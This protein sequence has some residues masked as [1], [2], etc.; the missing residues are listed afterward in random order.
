MIRWRIPLQQVWF[1]DTATNVP[2]FYPRSLQYTVDKRG[3]TNQFFYDSFG[4]VTQKVIIGNLTGEGISNQTATNTATYT[5]NN[6]PSVVKD[7]SGNGV[8]FTYDSADPFRPIQ[9]VRVSGVTPVATNYYA[10]TNVAQ[11]SSL[12]TTNFAFGLCWQ[13][14]EGG[15]TNVFGFN[16]NGFLIQSTSYPATPD[17]PADTDPAIIHYLSYNLRG[18]MY[19]DQTA[20]GGT[21]QF[22]FD[23]MGRVISKQVFDQ[24]NNN[25]SSE[26]NYYN[27]NGELEWYYGTR[28]NPQDYVYN[29]YDGAGRNIQQIK[30]RSQAKSD[31]TGVEAPA[32]AAAYATTFQTFDGFGDQTSVTDPRGVVITNL[33]DPLGR[34]IQRQ[35]WETNG[36]VLKTE[37]FA[38]ENG[39]KV[40][41]ATNALRGVTQTLYTQTGNPVF[42]CHPGRSHQRLPP[43]IWMAG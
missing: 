40:T 38:Y 11:V 2:G 16:G 42:R 27:R 6:L 18:Q 17:D 20:G 30:S 26:F 13:K 39:G 5:T 23:P 7:P 10:Y 1:P 29:I 9:T 21:I 12:G 35:V 37:Q 25:V 28:S 34:V 8:Q 33:F 32:G 41:L 22:D 3:L 43:I 14:I 24:N 31:G 15:A 4:N 19:Q 36:A